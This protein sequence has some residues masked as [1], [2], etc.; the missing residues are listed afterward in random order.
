MDLVALGIGF[1]RPLQ[2]PRLE[3]FAPRAV[4]R[5]VLV[6][7]AQLFAQHLADV[8]RE[9]HLAPR[10]LHSRPGRGLL[11]EGY[12][13]VLHAGD[14]TQTSCIYGARPAAD[15]PARNDLSGAARRRPAAR[16]RAA[17]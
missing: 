17:P 14:I 13:H 11:V 5:L 16:R 2:G 10:R 1:G 7:M 8:A 12:G 9:A 6:R 15:L 3:V 4:R